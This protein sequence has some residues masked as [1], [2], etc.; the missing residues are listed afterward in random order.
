MRQDI[1]NRVQCVFGSSKRLC[2]TANKYYEI[3]LQ[4]PELV[5]SQSTI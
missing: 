4:V 2:R 5:Q 3:Y 1:D